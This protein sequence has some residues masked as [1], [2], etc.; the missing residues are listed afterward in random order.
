V[1]IDRAEL[2][3]EEMRLLRDQGHSTT[4]VRI[5]GC[6]G[7]HCCR[8]PTTLWFWTYRRFICGLR[9]PEKAHEKQQEQLVKLSNKLV[10]VENEG[11]KPTGHA[12]V[13][14]NYERHAKNI[15]RDHER[16]A[17]GTRGLFHP[18]TVRTFHR[19]TSA[20]RSFRLARASLCL[21]FVL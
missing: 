17:R 20:Q 5:H 8:L 7:C 11:L 13:V 6:C 16:M 9:S 12:V 21:F 3:S 14:F 1:Q 10:E 4:D 18:G 19:L 15:L 2:Y